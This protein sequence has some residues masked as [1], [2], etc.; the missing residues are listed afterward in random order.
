MIGPFEQIRIHILPIEH[1]SN[2][3]I[4]FSE[5]AH[6]FQYLKLIG[7]K[8][9]LFVEI[10]CVPNLVPY[11]IVI[12]FAYSVRIFEPSDFIVEVTDAVQLVF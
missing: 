3:G 11:Q 2:L 9:N 12:A 7:K 6:F 1:D 10:Y 8:S 5:F 4:G